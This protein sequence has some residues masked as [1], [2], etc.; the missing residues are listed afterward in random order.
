MASGDTIETIELAEPSLTINQNN[1]KDPG[2]HDSLDE[3]EGKQLTHGY[4]F[5]I[6]ALL[7]PLQSMIAILDDLVGH[8]SL[9][10]SARCTKQQSKKTEPFTFIVH[11]SSNGYE[12]VVTLV[13]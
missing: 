11:I 13:D 7:E 12:F 8:D 1:T 9:H 4:I 6:W 10:Y 2:L 5:A 3:S